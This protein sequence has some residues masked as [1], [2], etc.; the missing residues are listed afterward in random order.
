MANLNA[1]ETELLQPSVLKEGHLLK[2]GR[3]MLKIPK[4]NYYVLR[5]S[6]VYCFEGKQDLDSDPSA[7]IPLEDISLSLGTVLVNSPL[8]CIKIADKR[9]VHMLACHSIEIRDSWMTAILTAVAQRLMSEDFPRRSRRYGL[10]ASDCEVFCETQSQFTSP[11]WENQERPKRQ[12]SR[13]SRMSV[14]ETFL[15]KK[16]ASIRNRKKSL[17]TKS[18]SLEDIHSI[19]KKGAEQQR[20]L[21]RKRSTNDLS[22]NIFWPSSA[23]KP[24]ENGE[25]GDASNRATQPPNKAS[26]KKRWSLFGMA[27]SLGFPLCDNN[28]ERKQNYASAKKQLQHEPPYHE[29]GSAAII[30]DTK[31]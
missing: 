7:F 31:L 17:S 22:R 25:F 15:E 28:S 20:P 29:H 8:H 30:C 14:P 13:R 2:L 18:F 26:G 16:T 10:C 24:T 3:S 6:G 23:G 19:F 9:K 27:S 4:L 12:R 5:P 11:F 1:M 21:T